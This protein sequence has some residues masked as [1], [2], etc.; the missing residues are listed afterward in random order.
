[1][2]KGSHRPYKR[3]SNMCYNR[4]SPIVPHPPATSNIIC[5]TKYATYLNNNIFD[6]NTYATHV[7]Q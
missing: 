4:L 3:L 6:V 1:M 5:V 7:D 2:P